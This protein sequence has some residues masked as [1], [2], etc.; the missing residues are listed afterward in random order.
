VADDP[1]DLVKVRHSE[2]LEERE[3]ARGALAFFENQG[4]EVLTDKGNVS[5][6]KKES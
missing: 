2:T 6:A 4:F 5:K 3:V 1:T